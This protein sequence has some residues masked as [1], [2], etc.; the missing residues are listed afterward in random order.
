MLF[1]FVDRLNSIYLPPL[2]AL[3]TVVFLGWVMPEADVLDEFTNHGTVA[4]RFYGV[5][6]FVARYIAPVALLV[7]MVSGIFM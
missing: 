6:R 1:D 7:V 5:F 3:L 4:R 2:C